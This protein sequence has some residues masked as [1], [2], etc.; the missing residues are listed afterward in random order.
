MMDYLLAGWKIV[1]IAK[2]MGCTPQNITDTKK[3]RIFQDELA[4][5]RAIQDSQ[6]SQ[7][8]SKSVSNAEYINEKLSNGARAAV[9][10][11]CGFVDGSEDC[12]AAIARQSAS[13]IL[14]RAG[15][16]KMT[17]TEN[18][19]NN[20]FVLDQDDFTRIEETMK[21]ELV[22]ESKILVKSE[23]VQTAAFETSIE[24]N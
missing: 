22:Q 16:P 10:K 2:T 17:K 20:I 1:D 15:Y 3:Q 8:L 12:S 7:D 18:T 11:L 19:Q 24:V 4:Q 9:E 13:D 23:T 5:R 21:M 14:D 6:V